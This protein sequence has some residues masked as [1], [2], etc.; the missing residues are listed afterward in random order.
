MFNKGEKKDSDM[1]FERSSDERST[2]MSP[3]NQI[4]ANEKE[5]QAS[6][7]QTSIKNSQILKVIPDWP[8]NTSNN[9]S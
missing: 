1:G 8:T 6:H 3:A 7:L 2:K 5:L 4:R 9:R